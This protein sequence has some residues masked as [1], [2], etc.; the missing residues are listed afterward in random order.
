MVK[1]CKPNLSGESQ[2]NKFILTPASLTHHHSALAPPADKDTTSRYKLK[3]EIKDVWDERAR[4]TV[5]RSKSCSPRTCPSNK[6]SFLV[7]ATE[8][9]WLGSLSQKVYFSS[10]SS[11]SS[12]ISRTTLRHMLNINKSR[13][14]S[15]EML[16]LDSSYTLGSNLLL[17]VAP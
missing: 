14:K 7:C 11:T 4:N 15:S 16:L 8:Y 6:L 9:N 10:F 12:S 3:G 17:Q 13:Q 2:G 1:H 5:L